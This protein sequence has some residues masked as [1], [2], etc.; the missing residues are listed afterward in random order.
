MR[1]LDVTSLVKLVHQFVWEMLPSQLQQLLL[2]P[3]HLLSLQ[4]PLPL[5]QHQPLTSTELS[6]SAMATLHMRE[7]FTPSIMMSFLDPCVMTDGEELRPM[8]FVGKMSITIFKLRVISQLLLTLQQLAAWNWWAQNFFII[9]R[10][11]G[12]A[13]G[14]ASPTNF[15]DVYTSNFAMDDVRCEGDEEHLQDCSYRSVDDCNIS[16]GAGVICHI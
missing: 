1:T 11:L 14:R 3:Q 4:H 7:M 13:G 6:F 12:F 16:E 5:S 8:W 2:Q 9:I 15:G 10:Q